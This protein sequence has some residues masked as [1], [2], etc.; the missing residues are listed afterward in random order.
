MAYKWRT[1]CNNLSAD[2]WKMVKRMRLYMDQISCR[3]VDMDAIMKQIVN[4]AYEGDCR[5]MDVKQVFG[6]NPQA[7]CNHL[8]DVYETSTST[9]K[10]INLIINIVTEVII[11]LAVIIATQLRVPY[12]YTYHIYDPSNVYM[13]RI[14]CILVFYVVYRGGYQLIRKVAL[15]SRWLSYLCYVPT[16]VFIIFDYRVRHTI[17]ELFSED[18]LRCTIPLKYFVIYYFY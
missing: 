2:Y 8:M 13:E 4:D 6:G 12:N 9:S 18:L 10:R 14:L 3:Q 5:H 17:M 15:R 7:Y 11:I 1:E 16:I